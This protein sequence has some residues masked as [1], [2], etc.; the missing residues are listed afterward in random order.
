VVVKNKLQKAVTDAWMY[1]MVRGEFEAAWKICD[2]VLKARAGTPCWHLPRHEQ[3]IWNGSPLNGKHILVRCYHGLGDAIQF[4]RYVPLI[5]E[6]AREVSVWAQP[7]LFPLLRPMRG[8]DHLLPLHDGAIDLEYDTD[9]E[10]MELAYIFRTKLETIPSEIP[11][12]HVDPAPIQ[13]D[14]RLAVGIVWQAGNFNEH[15]S[16]P[17]RQI[18]PLASV[19]DVTLHILQRGPAL[20]E[21]PDDFG[22]M[23]GSDSLFEAARVIKALDL[24]ITVDSMPAHLAGALGIPVWTLLHAHADWRW[25]A[26]RDNSPWY[27][28]MRLFRQEHGQDWER[29]IA[30]VAAEL[31]RMIEERRTSVQSNYYV[32]TTSAIAL[33]LNKETK[34]P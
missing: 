10:S 3:Y 24:V 33:T 1:H 17:F 16:I 20:D 11:Y 9:V 32:P 27:P 7:E 21:R 13:K 28:T 4:I 14:G 12:L 5:R 29:V 34:I 18:A 26:S 22:I 19:P 31:G 6:I 30:K 2:V 15:R 23:S 25:M 8:I